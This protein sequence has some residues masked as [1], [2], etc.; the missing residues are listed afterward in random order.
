MRATVIAVALL[1]TACSTG[2]TTTTEAPTELTLLTHDSFYVSEGV[3]EAFTEETGI[4]VTLLQAG[5]AGTIVSNAILTVDNPVAD[6]LFG[7]DSTF[8]SRALEAEVFSPYESPALD[9]V[10]DALEVGPE[11][12]PIDF[13]DVC[14]NVDLA[15]YPDGGPTEFA[16]LAL[17][18]YASQLVVQNP[19]TSS[20]G[21]AFLLATVAEFGDGWEDFW[22]D[23]TANG[24]EVTSG[25]EEAYYG[26]FTVGGGG[27]RPLVVS[28]ASSPPAEVIFA[29]PPVETAPT[30]VMETTC[31]RQVE[32]AGILTPSSSAEAL[33]DFMLS[34]TFQQDVPL[35]MFVF[36]AV[37]ATEL[38]AEFVEYAALPESP[39][40]LAEE[41]IEERRDELID[42]WTEIVLGS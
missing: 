28:Y 14:V 40:T 11:V 2:A 17:P 4:T 19:A 22:A 16:D 6:V 21:L 36:P 8:L 3:F 1:L 30:G 32:Y 18:E 33:I 9:G 41:E 35:S 42:R 13:G 34:E 7:V 26:S 27:D 20:P 25:W 12:T 39:L 5:D 10:P 31:F 24:V 15:A 23:L 29:D 38:P 37:A